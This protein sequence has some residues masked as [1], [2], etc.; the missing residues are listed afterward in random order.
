M[1]T[2]SAALAVTREARKR[3]ETGAFQKYVDAILRDDGLRGEV[4]LHA[5][6]RDRGTWHFQQSSPLVRSGPLEPDHRNPL[7]DVDQET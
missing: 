6:L 3:S 2:P 5:I 7:A 4:T 1:V